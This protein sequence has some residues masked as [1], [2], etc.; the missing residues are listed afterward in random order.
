MN[1][2]ER[3]NGLEAVY[4]FFKGIF[5]ELIFIFLAYNFLN[6]RFGNKI[7]MLILVVY[8]IF[9]ILI[10]F[11]EWYKTIYYFNEK[12][13]FYQ[14]GIVNIT[15][16]EVPLSK[17]NT[18]DM[19][20]GIFERIFKLT[21][22]KIDTGNVKNDE[23]EICLTVSSK[24]ASEIKNILIDK[25]NEQIN[26][27]KEK[28]YKLNLKS[29]II[30][31]LIS[32]AIL[33]GLGL[34]WIFNKFLD[35]IKKFIKFDI[36][37]YFKD[38][39]LEEVNN[40]ILGIIIFIMGIIIISI[41]L[42]IIYNCF[43][44][45]NFKTFL[46]ENKL[47]VSYGFVDRKNYSFDKKKIKGVHIK[48]NFLMQI[49]NMGTIEI[50][51]I[52][53]GDKKGEKAILYPICN[54]KFQKEIISE[55]LPEFCFTEQIYKSPTS[56][57][58]RFILKKII[59]SSIIFVFLIYKFKYAYVG[60]VLLIFVLILGY[61]QYKNTAIGISDTLVYMSY[62]GFYKTKSIIKIS[63]VQSSTISFDYFQK[64]MGLCDYTINIFGVFFGKNIKVKNM[65]YE[66]IESIK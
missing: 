11:L 59:F 14:N 18:I 42:S 46:E 57:C 30:Y 65:R 25:E 35:D 43:K 8:I 9:D 22:I 39:K 1:N 50:E 28:E 44:Y 21:R 2:I 10:C 32:N 33:K 5:K 31:S 63:A 47:N 23:S 6:K 27:D 29:L 53:Y 60:L 3:N 12:S 58:V 41:C 16:R 55:L 34:I 45:Y 20:Q 51:S 52:G 49:L 37:H 24:R 56:A 48:Q 7:A 36:L 61:M 38:I 26:T 13:I 64:R 15:K 40:K 17:I 66:L 4:E 62:N 54:E 19:S